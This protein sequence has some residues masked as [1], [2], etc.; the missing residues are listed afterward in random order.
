MGDITIYKYV[1]EDGY[2][3]ARVYKK[4]RNTLQEYKLLIAESKRDLGIWYAGAIHKKL[5]STD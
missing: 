2:K 1:I 4:E 3:V 5:L